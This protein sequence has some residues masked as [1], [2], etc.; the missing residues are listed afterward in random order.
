[1]EVFA[2][3]IGSRKLFTS[4]ELGKFSEKTSKREFISFIEEVREACRPVVSFP[5]NEFFLLVKSFCT[6]FKKKIEGS[7]R[8]TPTKIITESENSVTLI[9]RFL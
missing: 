2:D 1:V 6:L 3:N 4:G 5:A 7:N 8:A 9:K